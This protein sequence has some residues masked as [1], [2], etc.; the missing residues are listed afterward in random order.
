[1]EYIKK[2]QGRFFAIEGDNITIDN[3][4]IF[5][6]RCNYSG[7]KGLQ[8]TVHIDDYKITWASNFGYGSWASSYVFVDFKNVLIRQYT[9]INTTQQFVDLLNHY[10]EN[11]ESE[12][13]EIIV[14]LAQRLIYFRELAGSNIY[15]FGS[16]A[17]IPANTEFENLTSPLD[18][19][20]LKK[21]TAILSQKEDLEKKVNSQNLRVDHTIEQLKQLLNE[22]EENDINNTN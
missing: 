18:H 3:I 2:Q 15:F 19:R 12:K 17:S 9:D 8:P 21:F 5:D 22:L 1:M 11:G 20:A 6:S 13:S 16:K 10:V 7:V 4:S 14:E